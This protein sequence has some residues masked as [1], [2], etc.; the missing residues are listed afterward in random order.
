MQMQPVTSSNVV[1]I[2]YENG[3][4][5]VQFKSGTYRYDNVS[6]EFYNRLMAAESKGRFLNNSILPKGVRI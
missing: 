1:A 2:G 5:H 4:M 3:T 6:E